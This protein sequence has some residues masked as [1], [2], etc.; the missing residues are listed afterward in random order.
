[1]KKPVIT[2]IGRAWVAWTNT[3][4]TE[5]R[6][7]SFPHVICEAQITAER[8]GKG[9]GVQG[10][11]CYVSEEIVVRIDNGG[12]LGPCRIIAESSADKDRRLLIE[13]HTRALDKVKAA[14]LLSPEDLKALL[15]TI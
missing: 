14:G 12:W 4:L 9:H 2:E 1:M 7:Q 6:G 8:M 13:A 3:D 5:G 15:T 10:S 11:D